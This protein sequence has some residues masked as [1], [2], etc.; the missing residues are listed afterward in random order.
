MARHGI[1]YNQVSE[2]AMLLHRAGSTPTIDN[3]R[4]ILGTGSKTTIQRH[5]N[6]WRKIHAGL[7]GFDPEDIV[8]SKIYPVKNIVINLEQIAEVKLIKNKVQIAYLSGYVSGY[9]ANKSGFDSLVKAWTIY[10]TMKEGSK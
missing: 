3:V 1:T 2:A 8:L 4:A 7:L 9:T 6:S 5:M 10:T